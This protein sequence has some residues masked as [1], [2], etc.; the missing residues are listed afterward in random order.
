[1][2]E[3]TQQIN[4]YQGFTL[5]ELLIVVSII[6][7]VV[8]L[9]VFGL[10]GSRVS[11][12]NAKRLADLETIRAALEIYKSENNAYP[13]MGASPTCSGWNIS[14]NSNWLYNL[15]TLTNKPVDPI[16]TTVSGCDNGFFYRYAACGTGYKLQV[17]LEGVSTGSTCPSCGGHTGGT[18]GI[19]GT[20]DFWHCVTNP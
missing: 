19:A 16:N 15:T 18:Q 20:G 1:M 12:R 7:V 6:G 17:R 9:A 14:T 13:P 2:K 10:Q 3:H 5:I 11:A 8:T 4:R